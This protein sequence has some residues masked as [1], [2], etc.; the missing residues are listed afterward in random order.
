MAGR[1]F[2]KRLLMLVT[3]NKIVSLSLSSG[4]Q[5]ALVVLLI[6]GSGAFFYSFMRHSNVLRDIEEYRS[7]VA[8]LDSRNK[9]LNDALEEMESVM[10]VSL[11]YLDKLNKFSESG[12]KP[13]AGVGDIKEMMS[14]VNRRRQENID[15]N[16]ALE[17]RG[18]ENVEGTIT[19]TKK[20][21]D[22][23]KRRVSGLEFIVNLF[24]VQP[25][26]DATGGIFIPDINGSLNDLSVNTKEIERYIARLVSLNKIAIRLPIGSPLS[27]PYNI[28]SKFG[29]RSDP[30]LHK[31][32]VHN[33]VDLVAPKRSGVRATGA[34]KVAHAGRMGSYGNVVIIDHGYKVKTL[35]AHMSKIV[36]QRGQNVD[37]GDTIGL[38]GNTGRS[39]GTHLHYEVN[40][41]GKVFNP[42][43]FIKLSLH[44]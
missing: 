37:R 5:I 18:E 12:I 23:I 17:Q 6:W 28:S 16:R 26:Q 40:I 10:N 32:A 39:S 41:N 20:I 31:P 3:D 11:A 13:G 29:P 21:A 19:Y 34:G 44:G 25:E 33:G 15:H 42:E 36:V 30:F 4:I 2:E 7:Q 14:D 22:D 43:K 1:L 27:S 8:I 24:K 35:Y 38:I 9:T